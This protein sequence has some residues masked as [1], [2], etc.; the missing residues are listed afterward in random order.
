MNN[1]RKTYQFI[2]LSDV[3]TLLGD[4]FHLFEQFSAVG[5]S[6]MY[7]SK[8]ESRGR[9]YKRVYA[10]HI[11]KLNIEEVGYYKDLWFQMYIH[12]KENE[13]NVKTI[14]IYDDNVSFGDKRTD[15]LKVSENPYISPMFVM[16]DSTSYMNEEEK[17]LAELIKM[18][19]RFLNWLHY[20][21][22]KDEE[23]EKYYIQYEFKEDYTYNIPNIELDYNTK[24][25]KGYKDGKLKLSTWDIDEVLNGIK[26]PKL[27]TKIEYL[28]KTL[29][30][31]EKDM[32]RE[33][34][35][36]D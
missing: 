2:K 32:E 29:G 36:Y 27:K 9:D 5:Y 18:N 28:L 7:T 26:T 10:Q 20:M 1:F 30:T 19:D 35:D 15:N 23:L 6:K 8:E 4:E 22:V 33:V 24:E 17:K 34:Y 14:T 12:Y 13:E 16:R 21:G 11:T 3:L 25:F 31:K